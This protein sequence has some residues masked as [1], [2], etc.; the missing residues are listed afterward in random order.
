MQLLKDTLRS[1]VES[2]TP[3][4]YLVTHEEHQAD[5]LIKGLAEGR[6][7]F[8]WNMARGRV[9][10][11]TRQPVGLKQ[12]WCDLA[13][14]LE[15]WLMDDLQAHCLVIRD[16]HLGLKDQPLAIAR[17]KALISQILADAD[18][19]VSIF[20]VSS[21]ALIPRELEKFITLFE[22]PLPDEASIRAVI[23]QYTEAYEQ[24]ISD[25]DAT[26]M[27]MAFQGLTT[28]EIGQL[29][30]RGYQRDGKIDLGDLD[31]IHKEKAQI[32]KKSGI[33][34]M[35]PVREKLE[36]IGGLHNLKPWLQQKAK[37][38]NDWSAARAFGVE[39]PKGVMVV[40][41]P[42]CGK[43][44]TAKATAT[45]FNLPLLKL[46]MGA[47][48]GK[49]VGESE[50]NMRRA[51][52]V[53]EAVSPCVLWVDEVEKA[54]V[55]IG[56]GGAGSEVATRLF[57][58]FLTWMQEKTSQVFVIATANDISALPP[59]LLRKGRFDEI[60]YVDFPSKAERVDIFNVHLKKRRKLSS[61]ISVEQLADK[62]DGYSG[63]DIES[64]VTEAIEQA[65]VDNRAELDTER[66]L[67]VVNATHP[68]K[69]VMKT[70]VDEYQKKFAE[71]KIKKASK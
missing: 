37:V 12:E 45:L 51:I 2:H 62:T 56:S 17:L 34:E 33:L 40:G 43:S 13:T 50:G 53:A 5:E 24:T 9:D 42:G 61:R 7:I 48:M 28:Y 29:I 3:A 57:G 22:I 36:D 65:F 38:M 32:I 4:I 23:L 27:A 54:F 46:D 19:E 66:L 14:A 64:I 6:K 60:F 68:L 59:E 41:M 26:K 10:F 11:N 16:A 15:N 71:M 21:Q 58:Y 20:L 55:G 31:L 8:E 67:K 1:Y 47:L 52:Q 49:Y 25:D 44:L 70:K 30:T 63:A 35:P 18:A 69:E 39:M